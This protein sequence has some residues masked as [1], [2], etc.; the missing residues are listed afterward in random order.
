MKNNSKTSI[1]LFAIIV[2]IIYGCNSNKKR[3]TKIDHKNSILV[4]NKVIK[5]P[6]SKKIKY[7]KLNVEII[8]LWHGIS[9]DTFYFF[10][11]TEY[12]TSLSIYNSNNW[13][14]MGRIFEKG[15]GPKSFLSLSTTDEFF[16]L[17][18]E[19]FNWVYDRDTKKIRLVNITKSIA[20][21]T[22]VIDK[23]FNYK[24]E[25]KNLCFIDDST[26]I[27]NR[28]KPT[29]F[30][31]GYLHL[32]DMSFEPYFD[33]LNE[34]KQ[35]FDMSLVSSNAVIKPDKTKFALAMICFNQLLIT[36]VRGNHRFTISIGEPLS[37]NY[38]MS[39]IGDDKIKDQFGVICSTD[40][41]IWVIYKDMTPR[42]FRSDECDIKSK[43][44]VFDWDGNILF[45]IQTEQKLNSMILDRKKG[46]LLGLD[47]NEGI[48]EYDIH[49][50]IQL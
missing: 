23:E 43:I 21:N 42:E 18:N 13:K 45:N 50:Y 47:I 2:L 39:L 28:Y 34:K 27:C 25:L 30:E 14:Y 44:L 20:T 22:T 48:Y 5:L 3:E 24:D 15:E 17:N 10:R 11:T 32:H 7:K 40:K 6:E 29:N 41:Q 38:L 36:D 1:L 49:N 35:P 37:L 33:V 19:L 4:E 26:I 46:V 31:I 9:V 8:G 12:K 16:Y